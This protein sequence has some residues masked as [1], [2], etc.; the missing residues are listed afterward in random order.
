M[1]QVRLS[2]S[3]TE[4]SYKQHFLRVNYQV[5][6]VIHNHLPKPLFWEPAGNGWKIS[7]ERHLSKVLFEKE[8]API[9]LREIPHLYC[10][11]SDCSLSKKCHCIA[12]GLSCTQ[13]CPC[14]ATEECRNCE[15]DV[16]V[17]DSDDGA[18]ERLG[19][20]AINH[21]QVTGLFTL[22]ILCMVIIDN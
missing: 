14:C 20:V 21:H 11:D 7:G 2:F 18:A 8:P 17:D 16:L 5:A 13:F 22:Y 15:T 19:F 9:E 12:S 6:I 10:R 3:P 4:D 1:T